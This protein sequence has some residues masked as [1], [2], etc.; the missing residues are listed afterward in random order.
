MTTRSLVGEAVRRYRPRTSQSETYG[1]VRTVRY[2]VATRRW[3]A[4]IASLAARRSDESTP[5][6]GRLCHPRGY[7]ACHR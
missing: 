7:E 1:S 2:M 6:R 5:D 3:G 4:E